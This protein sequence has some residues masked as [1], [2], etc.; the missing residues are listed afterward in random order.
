MA[1]ALVAGLGS[2]QVMA[3]KCKRKC[4][5]AQDKK[6]CIAECKKAHGGKKREGGHKNRNQH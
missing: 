6:E 3:G 4:A 5:H 1:V 2:T